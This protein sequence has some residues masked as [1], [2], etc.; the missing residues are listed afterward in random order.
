M[1]LALLGSACAP[2]KDGTTKPD[3]N[4]SAAASTSASPDTR[5]KTTAELVALLVTKTDLP[6]HTIEPMNAGLGEIID[7]DKPE[8]KPLAHTQVMQS[9]GTNT[10]L[11]RAI[12]MEEPKAATSPDVPQGTVQF[13][14]T[15]VTLTSYEGTGAQDALATVKAAIPACAG[16][17]TILH[18]DV[19]TPV[20]GVKPDT[21]LTTGDESVSFVITMDMGK[22]VNKATHSV[23]VRK[24]NTLAT[25][26]A[27]NLNGEAQQPKTIIDTQIHKL[28]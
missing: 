9:I 27:M 21:E 15:S 2:G 19:T 12:V 18:K 25:F 28:H 24:G 17:F 5:G 23:V 26:W 8:C 14:S 11:A 10:G 22:G 13:T 6:T 1:S 20:A 16:G 7:T 3:S 4:Q